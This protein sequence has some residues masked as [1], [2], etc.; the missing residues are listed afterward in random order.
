MFGMV[1]FSQF[2]GRGR[3]LPRWLQRRRQLLLRRLLKRLRPA[4]SAAARICLAAGVLGWAGVLSACSGRDVAPFGDGTPM[5]RRYHELVASLST[6]VDSSPVLSMTVL[7]TVTYASFAEP[8]VAIHYEHSPDS[9]RSPDE[10][11]GVLIIGG[12]HGNEAAG[13]DWAVELIRELAENPAR[14]REF[15]IDI[16]P[17]VNPW[18]WAHDIRYNAD[19]RD[20]NRDFAWF[21]TQEAR[22]IR[23]F[24][25]DRHYDLVIDHHEDKRADGVYLYQYGLKDDA[26]SREL[27]EALRT[28]DYPIE[29]NTRKIILKTDDGLI[30]APVWGLRYMWLTD[31]LT[32]TNYIR[33]ARNRRVYT[34][35]TPVVWSVQARAAV[36]RLV[37]ESLTR[38]I[39]DLIG[40]EEL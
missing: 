24:L 39:A 25:A 32:I 33:L 13:T 27:I 6:V 4:L 10:T 18:G 40:T 7:G 8:M 31:Q 28:A 29:P 30:N 3:R 14:Y 16:V 12:V 17:A 38:R 22:W 15:R 37:F 1:R 5:V 20:I 34:V 11:P 36:H 19:G 9:P 35:E 2:D 21:R 23:D 26:W